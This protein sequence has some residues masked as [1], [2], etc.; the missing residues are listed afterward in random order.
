M[1]RI[2]DASPYDPNEQLWTKQ[3]QSVEHKTVA[4]KIS[5][6]IAI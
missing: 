6:R 5:I 4:R 1:L 3:R 2:Y